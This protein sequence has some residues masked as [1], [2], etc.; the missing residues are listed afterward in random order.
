MALVVESPAARAE[1]AKAPRLLA[2][3]SSSGT[4]AVGLGG[5]AL[6]RAGCVPTR[7]LEGW[8]QGAAAHLGAGGVGAA[9]GAASGAPTVPLLASPAAEPPAAAAAA[10][11]GAGSSCR[12]PAVVA[13]PGSGLSVLQLRVEEAPASAPGGAGSAVGGDPAS[14]AADGGVGAASGGP[15]SH[16]G[17]DGAGGGAEDGAGAREGGGGAAEAAAGAPSSLVLDVALHALTLAEAAPAVI[18]HAEAASAVITHEAAFAVITHAEAASAVITHS[19]AAPA[20]IT[21]A[22]A[23]LGPSVEADAPAGAGSGLCA[24]GLQ[25]SAAPAATVRRGTSV[26]AA[27][28]EPSPPRHTVKGN[29]FFPAAGMLGKRKPKPS[30]A[31]KNSSLVLS[32][33]RR[34]EGEAAAAGDEGR[35][36]GAGGGRRPPPEQMGRQKGKVARGAA[37]PQTPPA[38]AAATAAM[39]KCIPVSVAAATARAG[40]ALVSG[41]G[42]LHGA[43]DLSPAR[44]GRCAAAAARVRATAPDPRS[45]DLPSAPP[46]K[47]RRASSG[48]AAAP[49]RAPARVPGARVVGGPAAV[50]SPEW[51]APAAGRAGDA[52]V[53]AH[54]AAAAA[55][56][57]AVRGIVTTARL[58]A[59]FTVVPP[60]APAPS[61]VDEPAVSL[62][63]GAG[64]EEPTRSPCYAP[65]TAAGTPVAEVGGAPPPPPLYTVPLVEYELSDESGDDASKGEREGAAA[66]VKRSARVERRRAAPAATVRTPGKDKEDGTPAVWLHYGNQAF[67]EAVLV[68]NV[69]NIWQ[70]RGFTPSV[71]VLYDHYD[72][73]PRHGAAARAKYTAQSTVASISLLNSK[74]EFAARTMAASRHHPRTVTVAAGGPLALGD[75][76]DLWPALAK[77]SAGDSGMA[78]AAVFCASDVAAVLASNPVPHVV[79]HYVDAPLRFKGHKID[80]RCFVLLLPA[81]RTA[82]LHW[83]GIGRV[84][85]I[86]F[87]PLARDADMRMHLTN[88]MQQCNVERPPYLSDISLEDFLGLQEPALAARMRASLVEAVGEMFSGYLAEAARTGFSFT[89]FAIAGIDVLF[90][91]DGFAYVLECGTNI[92]Y[93]FFPSQNTPNSCKRF[94]VADFLQIV[95]S[96][97][98]SVPAALTTII[99]QGAEGC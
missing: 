61:P 33:F 50:S 39:G 12:R 23:A 60:T 90:N 35:G 8:T 71:G 92:T 81:A 52:G 48:A 13:A 82:Y 87:A 58:R 3:G 63:E 2:G 91:E 96:A 55:P 98:A 59:P 54:A 64:T 51:V 78:I 97:G 37:S 68:R 32:S 49:A 31:I 93:G 41:D 36:D 57:E 7:C 20:V 40:R 46:A 47:R 14:A 79:Q 1:S 25:Y 83:L 17:R 6:R 89:P 15:M 95:A 53:G 73:T 44:G 5:L 28:G 10:A 66:C 80:F 75:E 26:G 16:G 85:G 76:S 22:E 84:S 72:R 99:A 30:E 9:S 19:E 38:V 45:G 43:E 34:P 56:G 70:R 42:G 18:T 29:D 77:R 67:M 86:P 21:H 65:V 88:S 11:R 69:R 4:D 74:V 94:V 27:P 62:D 24:V